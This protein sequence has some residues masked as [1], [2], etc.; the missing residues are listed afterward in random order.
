VGQGR[1]ANEMSCFWPVEKSSNH[2]SRDFFVKA[3]G[4]G[5][6]IKSARFYIL[7]GLFDVCVLNALGGRVGYFRRSFR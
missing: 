3:L 4:Q 2:A 7:G 6:G 1:G 5:R